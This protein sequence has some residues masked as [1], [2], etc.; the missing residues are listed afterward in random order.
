VWEGI[1]V[2]RGKYEY[3]MVQQCSPTWKY[4]LKKIIPIV[5]KIIMRLDREL[6]YSSNGIILDK[7][8]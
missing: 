3:R 6:N 4:R 2:E 7:N 5:F 1:I 8:E